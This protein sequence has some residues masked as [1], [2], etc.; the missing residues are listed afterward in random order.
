MISP[1]PEAGGPVIPSGCVIAPLS[2]LRAG[3]AARRDA[4]GRPFPGS[5]RKNGLPRTVK[6]LASQGFFCIIAR[7]E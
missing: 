4:G 1:Q 6:A 5:Y 7:Q 2:G 3:Q